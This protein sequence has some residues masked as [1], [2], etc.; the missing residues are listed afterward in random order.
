MV[1]S[2]E[3]AD[4]KQIKAL[5]ADLNLPTNI[6]AQVYIDCVEEVNSIWEGLTDTVEPSEIQEEE[7]EK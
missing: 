2:Y 5:S 1:L 6:L 4:W 7:A 3:K